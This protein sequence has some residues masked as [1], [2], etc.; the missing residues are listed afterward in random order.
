[1]NTIRELFEYMTNIKETEFLSK[2]AYPKFLIRKALEANPYPYKYLTV[3]NRFQVEPNGHFNYG[4]VLRTV[5]AGEN[6]F[7]DFPSNIDY[8]DIK[9]CLK[10]LNIYYYVVCEELNNFRL[11]VVPEET[12]KRYPDYWDFRASDEFQLYK[13]LSR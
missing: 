13:E 2:L 12:Y 7:R 3:E 1:M 6:F 5:D 8:E 10:E 4:R 11:M 9:T